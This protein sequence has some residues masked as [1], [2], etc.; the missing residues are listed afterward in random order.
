MDEYTGLY[1]EMRRH[2][3]VTVEKE[4]LDINEEFAE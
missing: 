4:C 3:I 2:T 1:E